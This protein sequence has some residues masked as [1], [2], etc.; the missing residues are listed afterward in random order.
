MIKKEIYEILT[1]IRPEYDFMSSSDFIG[2]GFLDSFDVVFII[3]KI[4]ETFGVLI[5][6]LDVLPENF[7]NV[8]TIE[9]LINRS[10]KRD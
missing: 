6:G 1:E 10:K 8:E 9:A 3:S 7:S 5:D 4:E 2:D